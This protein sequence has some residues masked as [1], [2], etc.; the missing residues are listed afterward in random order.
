MWNIRQQISCATDLLLEAAGEQSLA[1]E[2]L[3]ALDP[4]AQPIFEPLLL[5]LQ[6][7]DD[8]SLLSRI[9]GEMRELVLEVLARIGVAA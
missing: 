9:A 5:A 3:L 1:R 8:R 4:S 6:A 2:A 7:I